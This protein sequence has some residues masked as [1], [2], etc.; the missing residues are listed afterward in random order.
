MEQLTIKSVMTFPTLSGSAGSPSV[1]RKSFAFHVGALIS[2][3]GCLEIS[4]DY[5]TAL[6]Q[7]ISV[8]IQDVLTSAN[9]PPTYASIILNVGLLYYV[10]WF[11]FF[12]LSGKAITVDPTHQDSN[13]DLLSKFTLVTVWW[14][15]FPGL[16]LYM[17]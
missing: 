17:I 10:R 6:G 2:I 13:K 1:C 5:R 16:S 9:P 11:S 14:E 4:A 7:L 8:T 12:N 3:R 15:V